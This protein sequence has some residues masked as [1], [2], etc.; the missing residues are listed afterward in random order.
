V[1]REDTRVLGR[2]F[3]HALGARTVTPR[4]LARSLGLLPKEMDG[5]LGVLEKEGL[6]RLRG[7]KVGLTDR[8]RKRLRVVFIGGGFEVIHAGHLHT[9]NEAK[10]L[11]D[12]LVAVVARDDTIRRRK[13]RDPVSPEDERQELLASLR[14]VDKALLGVKGNIYTMLERVR[15]DVVALGY[16]QYHVES[17]VAKEAAKRGLNIK[18]VRLDSPNPSLKTTKLLQEF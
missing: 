10:S 5:R 11:G 16:D 9:L 8:G 14:Q 2:I 7:K 6:V 3:V 13:G 12:V 4:E 1:S 17:E 15:P 18:V